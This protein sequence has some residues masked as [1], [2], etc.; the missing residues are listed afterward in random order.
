MTRN[1]RIYFIENGSE[2]NAALHYIFYEHKVTT[3]T[4]IL[5]F[6]KGHHFLSCHK[7]IRMY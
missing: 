4:G 7:K 3:Y 5:V 2:M 6:F 1:S